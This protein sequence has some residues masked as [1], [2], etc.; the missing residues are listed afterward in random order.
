LKTVNMKSLLWL[1]LAGALAASLSAQT[2]PAAATA[3]HSGP[4]IRFNTENCDF[5]RILAGDPVKFTFVATNTGDETLE[6]SGVRGS[7]SCVSVGDGP[8]ANTWTPQK[9]APGQTCR[10][11]VQIATDSFGSQ[12]VSKF[13]T[14]TSNARG[15]PTL[16]LQIH[17]EVWLPIEVVPPMSS[18]NV[19]PGA[20]GQTA[21]VLKIFNRM[22]TPLSLSDPQSDTN[23]FSAVLKTNVPG[24][25]FELTVSA[26]PASGLPPTFGMTIIQGNIRLKSSAPGM[27]PLKIG[28]FETLWPELTLYPTNL[29][30]P[31][32]PLAQPVTS[33]ITIRGNSA[34]LTLTNP[35]ANVPGVEMSVNVIQTNRQYYLCAVFPIGFV[36]QPG[37]EILLSVHTDNP[38]FPVLTVPVTP[39]QD[40]IIRRPP[41]PGPRRT[42]ILPPS[43]LAVP[44]ASSN[45]PAK[46]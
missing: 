4:A 16:D 10:I 44:G 11:P 1:A 20:D 33:H 40:V 45:A 6:I 12:P 31:A 8:A 32:G 5:G 46:P 27:N 15:R 42:G 19:I 14:V 17:G 21:D 36:I 25:E 22:E 38:H 7:C 13:V 41:V 35:A 30:I 43:I 18:F 37:R 26:A 28:V 39:M 34:N 24:S 3:P 29:Q 9:V 2:T 23:V